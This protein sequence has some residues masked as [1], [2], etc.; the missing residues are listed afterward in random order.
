MLIMP[1]LRFLCEIFHGNAI[2]RLNF[3]Y[4]NCRDPSFILIQSKS[5]LIDY[6]QSISFFTGDGCIFVWRLPHEM[7]ATMQNRLAQLESASPAKSRAYIAIDAPGVNPGINP[8]VSAPSIPKITSK[9]APSDEVFTS[10]IPDVA[11]PITPQ[12]ND[13]RYK[14]RQQTTPMS[15]VRFTSLYQG[16]CIQK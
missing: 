9:A 4:S 12:D 8:A 11:P 1:S 16:C 2:Q 15:F 14:S 6:N 10:S 13:Y 3:L 7:T 5:I